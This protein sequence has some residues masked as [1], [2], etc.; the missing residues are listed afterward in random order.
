MALDRQALLTEEYWRSF[1][2][3]AAELDHLHQ[4]ILDAGIP[5]TAA[6][7][8]YDL[9]ERRCRQEEACIAEGAVEVWPYDP[10]L[11]FD[12]GQ[13]IVVKVPRQREFLCAQG[14]VTGKRDLWMKGYGQCEAI[15]VRVGEGAKA[16]SK[17]YFASAQQ[18]FADWK[19][20]PMEQIVG[21]DWGLPRTDE[22]IAPGQVFE[23]FQGYVLR[24]LAQ[25]LGADDRFIRF[26]QEWFVPA[27]LVTGSDDALAAAARQIER[28]RKPLP[29]HRL[30]P[31]PEMPQQNEDFVRQ[32]SWN[33]ALSHDPRFDNVG[34]VD[35]PL[36]FLAALEPPEVVQKPL[37]LAIP[38]VPYTRQYRYL[39]RELQAIEQA[40]DDEGSEGSEE[41]GAVGSQP[42]PGVERL[43]SLEF[44]LN[45]AHRVAGTVPLTS[46][47]RRVFPRGDG[48]RTQITFIGGRSG[49]RMPAWVM[50]EDRYAW[51]LKAWYDD[52]L[53]WAGAC[54][55]LETTGNPLEMI[56]DVVPLPQPQEEPV[57]IARV[58]DGRLVFQWQ[59]RA[60]PYKYDPLM[61]IA[62]TRFE[63]V[64]AL[65]LEAEQ[66]GKPVFEVMCDLFPELARLHP[67]GHVHARTLYSA[68]NLVRRC[69]PGTVF[70]ELSQ[71]LCF[72]PVGDG[73]WSYDPD[74][75]DVKAVYQTEEE[76][77]RREKRGAWYDE[78]KRQAAARKAAE[79]RRERE[80]ELPPE[81]RAGYKAART[82]ERRQQFGEM[83]EELVG[84]ELRTLQEDNPFTVDEVRERQVKIMVGTTGNRRTIQRKEIEPAWEHLVEERAISRAEIRRQFSDFNPAYV[85]AILAALPGVT[86]STEPIQLFYGQ[87]AEPEATPE[88]PPVEETPEVLALERRRDGQLVAVDLVPTGPLFQEHPEAEDVMP[89]SL[90]PEL[91]LPPGPPPSDG[92]PPRQPPAPVPRPR[93][94]EA[95]SKTLFSRHYLD[96]RLPDHREWAEDFLPTFAAVRALWQKARQY[97]QNWNE[98][99]TEDEF[100]RPML[101]ALGWTFTVQP[102]A[103]KGGRITRPDY[104]LFGSVEAKAEADRYL[105]QD[106]PFYSRALAIAEAKYWGRPLSQKDV[107]GRN[108]W[109]VGSNPSHQ[110]VS[111]LVGTRVPWGILTN[112]LIWRLYSREVSSTASEFYEVDLGLVFDFLPDG[113]EPSPIQ[114]DQFRRWWLFFRSDGFQP[115]PHYQGKSFV[116]RVHEG[117]ATYARQISDKL[118]ELVF[119]RVIP[120][121]AGGFVAYRYHQQAIRQETEESL[122]EIYQATLSLLYKLL[123]L[124]YGEARGL[125]PVS[126]PGYREQSLTTLAQWAAAR[127]DSKQSPSDATHA[128]GKYDALLALF[129]RVDQ[130]DPS[131]GIPRYN[132]GLFN[133]AS[134]ENRFLEEHKLSDRVVARAVDTLI[135]DAGQPVDYAYISVRNLGAIYEGLLENKLHISPLPLGE[136]PGVRVELI[137]DKGER[138]ASGSYYT[139]DYI[140][141]YIVQH[142]LEPIL[143][144]REARFAAAM[145]RC[146]DLRRQ[147]QRT[148]DT[149]AVGLLRERLDEAE[150]QARE[151]FLG[152]KVCDPAMGS[153]HFLVN[154]VDHLTDGIIQRMQT[155]HDDHP[156]VLWKWNPI[157]QLIERLQDEILAE[158]GRQGI[159]V[160][161]RRLDDTALL[162][163]LV[164]KRCIYGVDLNPMAVELAKVSLWLHSFTV[165][166]PLSFLDHHLR[167]GNS[168]IGVWDI[169]KYIA[170]G[171][172]RWGDVLRTL[173]AMVRISSLTDSNASEV[174][175]SYRLYKESQEWIRP[176]KERLNVVLSTEFS[177]LGNISRAAQI[178]YLP[179]EDRASFDKAAL[180]KFELGQRVA[181]DKAFFHWKLEF[182]EAFIDL[183]RATWKEK[184][185]FDAV[186]GNPPYRN[187]W[188]MT[189][190]M[191]TDRKAILELLRSSSVLEGHWDLYIAFVVRALQLCRRDGYQSFILPNPV[192]RE[193]YAISLRREWLTEH[194]LRRILSF[195]EANVFDEV[196]RQCIVYVVQRCAPASGMSTTVET[197]SEQDDRLRLDTFSVEPGVWLDSYHSQIRISSDYL[198]GIPLVAKIDTQSVKLA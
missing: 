178:A 15:R 175:E 179:D 12:V 190:E 24:Q 53:I 83:I 89:E 36:W 2:L 28:A 63:D 90:P 157:Q 33:H 161:E 87:E 100:V 197:V 77:E 18:G 125:L 45:F 4:F 84:Q 56:V 136:G 10:R 40:I 162:T 180:E 26:G 50:H 67:Q 127:L 134:P 132:G 62:E 9:V 110:M 116:Q 71:R 21:Q 131:L 31:L 172:E 139:P 23:Q 156:H 173:T 82:R 75:R 98:A 73:Y 72:D 111:Y 57:R 34:T 78:A 102:K 192:L 39:H 64:E 81:E 169:E 13:R 148:S 105:G 32:F 126:H 51:G 171:S 58:K 42:L 20:I 117:S 155:Y 147:L 22:Y 150:R 92:P 49:E 93:R 130:G 27:L 94:D 35:T 60:I 115:D 121:I 85:A 164:M 52:N 191:P 69:A 14:V 59:N 114:M 193:K 137:N 5:Q 198:S 122:R 135:R 129:H 25:Q 160:D 91:P 128:T 43:P 8:A 187:A 30:T 174:E 185:G 141:K 106:D 170:P 11:Q 66:V 68:A 76:V 88:M 38:A 113:A 44:V 104:A 29:L 120:E 168:L 146:A 196:S 86:H 138:K 176:T 144:E 124:L 181:A 6:F 46:R 37:R 153:G 109:K 74:L 194:S 183:E 184:P 123:F 158:M 166:A 99:Q 195:G 19:P 48:P 149:T 177:E 143:D 167:W 118:K 54:I 7:L 119:E 154:A 112:G 79:T 17:E 142:T 16:E 151:A 55:Q 188:A 152:I 61:L 3:T 186:I 41:T 80:A 107:S 97:G 103:R 182:P 47:T 159:A 96:T 189:K 108:T 101:K 145:D 163:R 165:G 140:V 133:P 95:Q 65:W 70:S 1:A